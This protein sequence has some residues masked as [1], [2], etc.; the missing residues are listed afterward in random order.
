MPQYQNKL[1]LINQELGRL[2]QDK[3]TDDVLARIVRNNNPDFYKDWSNEAI[4]DAH[5]WQIPELRNKVRVRTP[6]ERAFDTSGSS[7]APNFAE[8]VLFQ[9]QNIWN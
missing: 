6:G 1:N 7:A 8:Q 5:L 2:G 9:S 3:I 4:V